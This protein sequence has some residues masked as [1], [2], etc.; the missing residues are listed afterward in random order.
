MYHYYIAS[1]V[2]AIALLPAVAFRLWNG[3]A[4]WMRRRR[5]AALPLAVFLALVGCNSGSPD[6]TDDDDKN[7]VLTAP[8]S[9]SEMYDGQEV[10]FAVQSFPGMSADDIMTSVWL[11]KPL[12]PNANPDLMI[13][14]VNYGPS[15]LV[16]LFNVDA[17]LTPGAVISSYWG[18]IA[19]QSAAIAC[20]TGGSVITLFVRCEKEVCP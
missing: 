6:T 3:G 16:P 17:P 15:V 8:C 9:V 13:S 20:P 19:D 4:R 2:I 18:L 7:E 10:T 12:A 1:F 11:V 14:G 5:A